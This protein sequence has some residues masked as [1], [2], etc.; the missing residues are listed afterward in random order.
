MRIPDEIIEQL[1]QDACQEIEEYTKKTG[2]PF[3]FDDLEEMVL[4][5]HQKFGNALMRA[6]AEKVITEPRGEKKT[7]RAA[8]GRCRRRGKRRKT[9]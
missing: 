1:A 6:V 9:S 2:K 4:R 5:Y 7:A 3:T 8:A